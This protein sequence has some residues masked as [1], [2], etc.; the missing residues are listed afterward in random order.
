[1]IVLAVEFLGAIST[2]KATWKL[3]RVWIP[4]NLIFVGM[5]VTGMYSLKHINVAMVTILKN[6]T[7][8][9]TAF[10]KSIFFKKRQNGKVWVALFLMIVS[11]VNG[12]I[13]DLSFGAMG[14]TWQIMNAFLLTSYSLTL[15]KV[16]DTVKRSVKSGS[17]NEVSMVFLNNSLSVPFAIVLII[18]SDEWGYVSKEGVIRLPMFWVLLDESGLL[19]VAISF[20]SLWFLNQTSPTTYSLVGSLNKIPIS[21]CGILLFKVPVS[22]PNLF[23]IFVRVLFFGV[24]FAKAK[25]S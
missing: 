12:G 17:L 5:L 11:A 25:M 1:M 16:M 15:R 4:V 18:L 13:T 6:M 8:I 22:L 2:K 9:L 23:S 24:F 20:T 10:G 7:N 19:G 21:I 14:Y 3:V